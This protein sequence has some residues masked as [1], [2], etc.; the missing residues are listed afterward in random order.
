MSLYQQIN[1]DL[2]TAMKARDAERLSVLRMLQSA[3]KNE[4]INLMKP[5]LTDEEVLK[6]IKSEVKKRKDSEASY[7][8]GGRNDL[9]DKENMEARLL[10]SYLPAQL[11]DEDLTARVVEILAGMS[12]EE[13]ANLGK[14][15]GQVMKAVGLAADGN[16][17]RAI[18]QE[19]LGK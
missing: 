15:M 1:A 19:K 14:A 13:K 10:E 7:Q 12:D 2:V 18:L 9:A 3:L 4:A 6:A 5:E 16:R 17:V 8:S 11:T